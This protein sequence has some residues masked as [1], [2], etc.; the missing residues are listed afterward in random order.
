MKATSLHFQNIAFLFLKYFQFSN[1]SAF[2]EITFFLMAIYMQFSLFTFLK[3]PL[4][5]LHLLHERLLTWSIS[6][7]LYHRGALCKRKAWV[8]YQTSTLSSCEKIELYKLSTLKN[9][10]SSQ[11]KGKFLKFWLVT[12]ST[13]ENIK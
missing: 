11:Y 10:R 7:K 12:V 8:K 6:W 2:N 4:C 5:R 13:W 3:D 9:F 1:C